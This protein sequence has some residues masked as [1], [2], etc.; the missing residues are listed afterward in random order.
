MRSKSRTGR[1]FDQ[2]NANLKSGEPKLHTVSIFRWILAHLALTLIILAMLSCVAFYIASP[3]SN[4]E[5]TLINFLLAAVVGTIVSFIIIMGTLVILIVCEI[6]AE[7][8]ST[9]IIPRK[10]EKT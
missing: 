3:T 7:Y 4:R 9:L 10:E 5:L 1:S 6:I 2:G 8:F